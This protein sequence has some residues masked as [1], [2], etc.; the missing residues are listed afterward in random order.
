MSVGLPGAS[1]HCFQTPGFLGSWSY[2][3]HPFW[4]F[5]L[6]PL[7]TAALQKRPALGLICYFLVLSRSL[8]E[9]EN[10]YIL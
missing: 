1:L 6:L 3:D 4:V 2:R 7:D 10:V 8:K 9:K 5:P